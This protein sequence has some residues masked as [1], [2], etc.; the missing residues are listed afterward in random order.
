MSLTATCFLS[1]RR[2]SKGICS[3]SLPHFLLFPFH[4]PI[5]H[6][7]SLACFCSQNLVGHQNFFLSL[8]APYSSKANSKSK[9]VIIIMS[10]VLWQITEKAGMGGGI[11]QSTTCSV[12]EPRFFSGLRW[13]S[14]L[15]TNQSKPVAQFFQTTRSWHCSTLQ[16]AYE[17]C[18]AKSSTMNLS[19]IS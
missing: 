4:V 6:F 10:V 19:S 13:I 8:L 17:A 3:A 15:L 2:L 9:F 11:T 1:K 14:T 7:F 18:Y 12:N 16:E 5:T